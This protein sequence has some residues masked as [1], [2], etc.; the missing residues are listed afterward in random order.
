LVLAE[1][2]W[3]SKASAKKQSIHVP[4]PQKDSRE[5]HGIG[6]NC[7]MLRILHTADWHLGQSFHGFD[8]D[9]EHQLF[10]NWLLGTVE[11][12]QPDAL[13]IA[14]DVFDSV[15]PSAGAQRRFYDF[16][17]RAHA[18]APRLQ[19]IAI[20]GNHD[21]AARLEAPAGLFERLN[22]S[23]VGTV[24][25]GRDGEI[26]FT[27]FLVPLKG[28]DGQVEA[29]ALAV[30]FLRPA[31]VP[32]VAESTDPY[33]D[34]MRDLYL[35]VTEAARGLR[36]REYSGAALVALGH[37]HI[38]GAIESR[39]SE[40]RLVVGG[41]EAL[42]A[43][44]FP[45][46]LAYVALG[47]LHKPQEFDGRICYCGS[48]IPL[49]FSEKDYEHRVIELAIDR[50]TIVS[51]TSLPI[52]KSAS[53]VRLPESQSAKIDE[54]L[55]LL[56]DTEFDSTL[57]AEA[58]P[59]LEIRLLDDGPDPTRRRRI[60]AALE[61]K[62]VRLASIK[63]EQT[64]P[65]ESGEAAGKSGV[66]TVEDLTTLDPEVILRGAHLEKFGT[67]PDALVLAAFREVLSLESHEVR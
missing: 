43:E 3:C 6:G 19:I 47:H 15:N 31:D 12:R 44:T 17:A 61:G 36:E 55:Q 65:A 10:L 11:E 7:A 26:D 35:R 59:F 37:C 18:V 23:V 33:L 29:I 41:A 38:Q 46:D 16:L 9:Y 49:S 48:P 40:R 25:R 14:G 13:L 30:P 62:A 8:R 64:A 5:P 57:P 67:E 27:K 4:I 56:A 1:S 66:H 2:K 34:G 22:I 51:T 58:H 24:D 39:D 52:P 21:A 63:F 20:A 60:E 42:K 54:L 50:S 53:L 32:I 45:I 28:V